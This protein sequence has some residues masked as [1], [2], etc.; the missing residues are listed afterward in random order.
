MALAYLDDMV[1]AAEVVEVFARTAIEEKFC[2]VDGAFPRLEAA[3]VDVGPDV[4]F[5][6]AGHGLWVGTIVF[7]HQLHADVEELAAR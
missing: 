6:Q 1:D 7:R 4:G 2:E 5:V 3:F